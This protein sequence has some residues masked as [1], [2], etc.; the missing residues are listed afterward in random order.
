MRTVLEQALEDV[1]RIITLKY[2]NFVYVVSDYETACKASLVF[3]KALVHQRGW[4][5]ISQSTHSRVSLINGKLFYFV[6]F[7]RFE[8]LVRTLPI[9]R[10]YVDMQFKDLDMKTIERFFYVAF[11]QLGKERGGDLDARII[12]KEKFYG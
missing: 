2:T 5:F 4:Q 6:D 11:T 9:E 12:K 10:I 3:G 1:D 8:T 7:E